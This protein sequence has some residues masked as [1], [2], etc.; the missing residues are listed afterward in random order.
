MSGN[1]LIVEKVHEL[2]AFKNPEQFV[3]ELSVSFQRGNFS[4][5]FQTQVFEW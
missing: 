5:K 2:T 3:N 1:Y 4:T